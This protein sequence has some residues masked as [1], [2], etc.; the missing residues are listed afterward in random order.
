MRSLD[1]V[2]LEDL[3]KLWWRNLKTLP[4]NHAYID[5]DMKIWC[6][7]SWSSLICM[8]SIWINHGE[9]KLEDCNSLC[10]PFSIS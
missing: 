7:S 5:E 1:G 6:H 2:L 4:W 3:M 8:P 9:N 10:R